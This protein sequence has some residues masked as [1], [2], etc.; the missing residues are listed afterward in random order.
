MA[1]TLYRLYD[2]QDEADLIFESNSLQA[3][4]DYAN[5]YST[6][7]NEECWLELFRYSSNG[8]YVKLAGWWTND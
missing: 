8:K 3:C 1:T 2:I 7:V 5:Y 6:E 4:I